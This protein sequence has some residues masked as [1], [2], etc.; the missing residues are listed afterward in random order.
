MTPKTEEI[1]YRRVSA[2]KPPNQNGDQWRQSCL[3]VQELE[4]KNRLLILINN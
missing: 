2:N 4:E 1:L 3:K